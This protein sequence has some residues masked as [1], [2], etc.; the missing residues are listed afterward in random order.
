MDEIAIL[1]SALSATLICNFKFCKRYLENPVC[2]PCGHNICKE[3]LE[4]AVLCSICGQKIQKLPEGDYKVNEA[5]SKILALDLHYSSDK[6]KRCKQNIDQLRSSVENFIRPDQTN[7]VNYKMLIKIKEEI[8]KAH[9]SYCLEMDARYKTLTSDFEK[10]FKSLLPSLKA[11]YNR[12]KLDLEKL[13]K[14][15]FLKLFDEGQKLKLFQSIN[16]IIKIE[17]SYLVREPNLS[18]KELNQLD[19]DVKAAMKRFELT[20]LAAINLSEWIEFRPSNDMSLGELVFFQT[21][22][23][24]NGFFE[25]ETING[26]RN[27]KGT[28]YYYNNSI[29]LKYSEGKRDKN[30]PDIDITDAQSAWS[31]EGQ[32]KNDKRHGTCKLFN[33]DDLIEIQEWKNGKHIRNL[34]K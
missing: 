34:N 13:K 11:Q 28:F 27:G 12:S 7:T 14:K 22:F 24:K 8:E 21:R 29:D 23:Y 30:I 32:W 3:H 31:F 9:K 4:E 16:S 6:Q 25:G 2:L 5:L 33:N 1:K 19:Q 17:W 20:E 26:K 10:Y 18:E 15:K